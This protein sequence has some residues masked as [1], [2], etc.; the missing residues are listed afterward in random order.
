MSTTITT[1]PGDLQPAATAAG[2]DDAAAATMT[3]ATV[4]P[5]IGDYRRHLL[6]CTGPRCAQ[7]GQAQACSTAWAPSS[8]PQASTT[9]TCA[10]S[11]AA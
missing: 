6:I 9:A 3:T 4:R 11:A 2:A 5:K 8:R 10:S 1:S 7:E